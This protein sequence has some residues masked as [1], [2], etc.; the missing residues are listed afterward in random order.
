MDWDSWMHYLLT[1]HG[2]ESHDSDE[3][4]EVVRLLQGRNQEA[5]NLSISK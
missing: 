5:E 2:A 4:D 3:E 1:V